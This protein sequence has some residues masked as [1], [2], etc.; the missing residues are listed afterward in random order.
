MGF[1]HDHSFLST[2]CFLGIRDPLRAL[3]VRDSPSRLLGVDVDRLFLL[4][5]LVSLGT[6]FPVKIGGANTNTGVV[7]FL[8]TRVI[9]LVHA[10]FTSN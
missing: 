6:Q 9:V 3:F 10:I 4:G 1:P 2:S 5:R 7:R 8:P